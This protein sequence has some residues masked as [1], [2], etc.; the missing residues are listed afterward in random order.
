MIYYFGIPGS[1]SY[2]D[3]ALSGL[4]ANAVA[5][6]SYDNDAHS[7]NGVI[8]ASKTV[9]LNSG[10]FIECENGILKHTDSSSPVLSI[11]LK[12]NSED[13]VFS[14]QHAEYELARRP[15]MYLLQ[16]G[17]F[18]QRINKINPDTYISNFSDSI[19]NVRITEELYKNKKS[20]NCNW[21]K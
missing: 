1:Y 18:I 5:E 6:F 16:I 8:R 21:Y 15:D 19:E 11:K 10:C 2:S 13:I 3:D 12:S 9:N 4:E 7:L 17:E 14:T 20:L